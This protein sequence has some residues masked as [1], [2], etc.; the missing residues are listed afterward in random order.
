MNASKRVFTPGLVTIALPIWKRLEYLPH[1][2]KII[3]GQDYPDIE[4]IVSDNG[5][6]ETRVHDLVK[7]HYSRPFRFR[8]NPETVSIS[9][10]FNQILEVASG[11]YF[12]L[13]CDDDE[14]SSNY[15]S[16]LVQQLKNHP[17]VSVAYS[18][19]E[20]VNDA[21]VVIRKSK[22]FPAR[23]LSGPEFIRG[24]WQTFE[25]G[26]EAIGTFVA[27]TA[28]VVECGGYPDFV[29]GSGIDNALITK[30]SLNSMVGLSPE[31][32][33]RWRVHE[34]GYGWSMSAKGL[35]TAHIQFMRFLDTDP[36]MRKLTAVHPKEWK[37]LRSLLIQNEWQTYFWRW[38]DIY[39]ERL[40]WF[41]W[42]K[43]AFAMPFIL[44]YVSKRGGYF[45]TGSEAE[46]EETSGYRSFR[47]GRSQL[48]RTPSIDQSD[49]RQIM[50]S[51][52]PN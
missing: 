36:V 15:I 9:K 44:P 1:I 40:P 48:F 16:T 52:Q 32:V 31:C 13:I 11:E 29:R 14:I 12:A 21:G 20:I 3:A 17:E 18:R 46:N 5:E 4:L 51:T 45:S 38:R 24:L 10:H 43:A 6:N 42:A 19:Q 33:W 25:F 47:Y 8:Q 35:A 49:R 2:L 41:E 26:F 7:A 27:R 22:D 37:E 28:N 39:K 50:I 30:L 23:I 34:S